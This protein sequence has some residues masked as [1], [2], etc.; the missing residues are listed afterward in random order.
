MSHIQK[1]AVAHMVLILLFTSMVALV[2][3][4]RAEANYSK[5]I[6]ALEEGDYVQASS[7]FSKCTVYLDSKEK[8]NQVQ[9]YIQAMEMYDDGDLD[10]AYKIFLSL[11]EFGQ[12]ATF[13]EEIDAALEGNRL[14]QQYNEACKYMLQNKYPYAS[15][16]FSGLGDHEDS[17]S[18]ARESGEKWRLYFANTLSAGIRCSV[19]VTPDG[20]V[21]LAT[22]QSFLG[23]TDLLNWSDI[24]SVSVCGEIVIGLKSDGTVVTAK[25]LADNR[26]DSHI[27]TDWWSDIVAVSAG[28]QYVVGLRRDGTVIAASLLQPDGYGE[29]DVDDWDN[30]V[31]IDTGWQLTAGLDRF[32]DVHVTGCHAEELQNE[33]EAVKTI[34]NKSNLWTDV[35]AISVGGSGDKYRGK[36]HIVGL[37]KDGRVVAVGDNNFGQC[38]VN[39]WKDIIAV[40]AGDYHTV[41][42]TKDGRVL[43]TQ[44]KDCHFDG[45]DFSDSVDKIAKWEDIIAISAGYGYTLGL[46]SDGTVVAAGNKNEGQA[47][48][49]EWNIKQSSG[50]IAGV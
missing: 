22:R 12:S 40:S 28:Q 32:G 47:D 38:N 1:H 13:L 11:G 27:N 17:K 19:G 30:I 3:R 23:K 6:D 2:F 49:Q 39:E 34:K 8:A 42:L 7:L 20:S 5:A 10:D 14:E 29:T 44:S 37:T 21:E 15:I 48:V 31:A 43:T 24:V 9:Q 33:I 16:L 4:I 35:V 26:Y 41:A 46:K 50:D 25:R 36:G 45:V 18:L